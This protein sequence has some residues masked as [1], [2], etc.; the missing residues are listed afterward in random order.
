MDAKAGRSGDGGKKS[1]QQSS[2]LS[3]P[4]RES[5]AQVE[6]RSVSLLEV[7]PAGGGSQHTVWNTLQA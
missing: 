5:R 1:L 2:S 3:A 6:G 7:V 4:K